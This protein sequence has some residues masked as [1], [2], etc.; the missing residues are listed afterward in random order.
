MQQA[1]EL[2]LASLGRFTASIAHELRNPLSA[3]LQASQLLTASQSLLKSEQRFN[4][5]IENNCNRM[6]ELIRN[7][8]Q[9]SRQEKSKLDIIDL[10]AFLVTF[11]RDYSK[12]KNID[13]KFTPSKANAEIV[14]DASQLA[15]LF[16]IIFDNAVM[17]GDDKEKKIS[18]EL[19]VISRPKNRVILHI[20]DNGKGISTH[21]RNAIF[22]PFYTT[23][24]QGVGL[25]LF[26]AKELCM[27]NRAD[28]I[29][30]DNRKTT[31][32]CF[33]L[34]FSSTEYR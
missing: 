20:M 10:T 3:I 27:A 19:E 16:V 13:I 23:S 12:A 11:M 29:L 7:V 32:A 30:I 2:K 14:F 17:H 24:R 1:Q 8:L 21:Q 22:E 4:Q 25:G 18:V 5:I 28:I 15:Q 33:E 31:G 9:L 26:L 34:T 6:N